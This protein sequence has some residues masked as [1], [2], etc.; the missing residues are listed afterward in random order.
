MRLYQES[1]ALLSLFHHTKVVLAK[2]MFE[3]EFQKVTCSV[4][5]A[6]VR[7]TRPFEHVLYFLVTE[8]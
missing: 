4:M 6:H 5:H 2:T 3:C 7:A 1:A 8:K